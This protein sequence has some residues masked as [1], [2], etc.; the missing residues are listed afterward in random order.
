MK[1]LPNEIKPFHIFYKEASAEFGSNKHYY[2]CIYTQNE[3]VNN[4]LVNDVYGLMITTNQKY[5][6]FPNDYNVKIEINGKPCFVLCDKLYRF[7]VEQTMEVKEY[8]LTNYQKSEVVDK[9]QKFYTEIKR[10]MKEWFLK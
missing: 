3:D 4:H 10:Q 7:K 1:T 5:E 2:V 6:N 8:K 9:L